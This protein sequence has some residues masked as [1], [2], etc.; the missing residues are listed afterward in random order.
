MCWNQWQHKRSSWLVLKGTFFILIGRKICSF[1]KIN[2]TNIIIITKHCISIYQVKSTTSTIT[3]KFAFSFTCKQ[4]AFPWQTWQD[5]MVGTQNFQKTNSPD[6]NLESPRDGVKDHIRLPIKGRL[7]KKIKEHWNCI[8]KYT[9]SRKRF[10]FFWWKTSLKRLEN[11]I[12]LRNNN[13]TYF[14]YMEAFKFFLHCVSKTQ[15]KIEYFGR[16]SDILLGKISPGVF[17]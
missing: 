15:F 10:D 1:K 12:L 17:S 4:V 2:W 8:A 6:T 9:S 16:L 5:H 7:I 14:Y 11:T 3:E 13:F